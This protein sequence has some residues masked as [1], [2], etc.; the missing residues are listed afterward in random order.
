MIR[1]CVSKALKHALNPGFAAERVFVCVCV[2]LRPQMYH[3]FRS[4]VL[5]ITLSRKCS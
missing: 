3:S 1:D 4:E 2:C 5:S